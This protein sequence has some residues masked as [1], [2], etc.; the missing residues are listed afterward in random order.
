MPLQALNMS[1]LVS[2]CAA[3]GTQNLHLK[4]SFDSARA[5]TGSQEQAEKRKKK[6]LMMLIVLHS[7]LQTKNLCLNK[8]HSAPRM[9]F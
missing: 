5:G 9:S 6:L 2:A 1:P 8:A 4:A 3:Q 7:S